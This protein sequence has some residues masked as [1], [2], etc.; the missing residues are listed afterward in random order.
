MKKLIRFIIFTCAILIATPNVSADEILVVKQNK[1]VYYF[2]FGNY[3]DPNMFVLSTVLVN[4]QVSDLVMLE[5]PKDSWNIINRVEDGI[6]F[7]YTDKQDAKIKALS[8]EN[9]QLKKYKENAEWAKKVTNIAIIWFSVIIGI[10]VLLL[11]IFG[12]KII[13]KKNT[14]DD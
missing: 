2:E 13:G 10:F 12:R 6:Y 11:I 8:E 1:T 7:T 9:A 14:V 4:P 5:A 3:R